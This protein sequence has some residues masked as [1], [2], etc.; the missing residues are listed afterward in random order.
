MGNRCLH[1][2]RRGQS[3]LLNRVKF[4]E[5]KFLSSKNEFH[6]GD[7]IYGKLRPYLDKVLVADQA[8][9]C[10]T[11]MI[12]LRGFDSLSPHFIRLVMKAPYFIRYA[13]ESTH[14]MSLPR[15]GTEKAREALIPLPP[16]AEQ[17]RIVAKVDELMALC[18]RLEQQQEHSIETH[19]TLV[20]TLLDALTTTS[21]NAQFQQAWQR[22][23][24]KFHLLFTTES[25][26]DHLKQTILQLAVM[27][28]LAPQDLNDEPVT[29][30][31]RKVVKKRDRLIK[32]G[33]MKKQKHIPT[34]DTGSFNTAIPAHWKFCNLNELILFMDAG[35]SPACP[36]M[37]SP[38]DSIWGVLKTT[39]VQQMKYLECENKVLGERKNPRP[40]YEV[41]KGDILITRA[42]PKNRVGVSCL[43]KETRPKLMI[44]DKIIRF[45]LL[46][47]DLDQEFITLCLNSGVTAIHLELSKSGMAESQMNI[48]QSKLQAAPIPLP[49]ANE[50][51]RIVAKVNELMTLC[52]AIKAKLQ[53][54][55]STQITLTDTLAQNALI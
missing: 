6:I 1:R 34:P 15:M 44:S 33:K 18:D 52:D 55:Q 26:I 39:A 27:G 13:S 7:V 36:T 32:D 49:P 37:Q 41:N 21:T 8:G 54:A 53:A 38:S 17:H 10:T 4:K 35:W 16:L 5:R 30:L 24:N 47:D 19:E 2:N 11:E 25:S 9:V 14:G 23:Q 51:H 50:Q 31:L 46:I 43:V 3:K 40:Q 48:S 28:K 12:P 29:E 42:G 45:H 22:I 20:K